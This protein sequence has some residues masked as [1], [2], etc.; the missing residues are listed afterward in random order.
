MSNTFKTAFVLL[1]LL[2]VEE[3]GVPFA[4]KTKGTWGQIS[5]PAGTDVT[6]ILGMGNLARKGRFITLDFSV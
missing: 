4:V 5:V 2:R 3:G 6:P 1:T